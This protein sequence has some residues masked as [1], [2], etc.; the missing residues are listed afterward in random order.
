MLE[1]GGRTFGDHDSDLPRAGAAKAVEIAPRHQR[2]LLLDAKVDAGVY[3][4]IVRGRDLYPAFAREP[5]I[6]QR[7]VQRLGPAGRRD[8]LHRGELRL[9]QR[10]LRRIERAHVREFVERARGPRRRARETALAREIHSPRRLRNGGE[11]RRLGPGEILDR[12]V[13]IIA[14]RVRDA[15]ALGAIG[16]E[17]Q[18]LRQNRLMAVT[19]DQRDRRRRLHDLALE[20]ARAGI[21]HPRH[22]HRD[23]RGA[24]AP[25]APRE[26]I[27][28]RAGDRQKVDAA[29]RIKAS[30]LQ[31]ESR[32]HEAPRH[33]LQR[34]IAVTGALAMRDL[35]EKDAVAIVNDLG[36]PRRNQL[37]AR[38]SFARQPDA[39]ANRRAKDDGEN[40]REA[41]SHLAISMR[42][43]ALAPD[44]PFLYMVSTT[45]E[46]CVNAPTVCALARKAKR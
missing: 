19:R 14:R 43:P 1:G 22:L 29:M 23:G 6:A 44:T 24:F 16:R 15:V 41:P 35:R 31:S 40:E 9:R 36:R 5:L 45:P 20:P 42:W 18:I 11:Q 8:R 30:I 28:G 39:A 13:E 21:L 46:G 38:E 17:A 37:R 10:R 25:A 3:A 2:D 26:I 7:E 12:L 32:R 34:P 4:R 33:F 27:P